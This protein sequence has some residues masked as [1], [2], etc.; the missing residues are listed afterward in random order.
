MFTVYVDD[1]GT[2]PKQAVAIASHQ[3][4]DPKSQNPELGTTNGTL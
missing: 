4:L 3:I 1:S 2:D